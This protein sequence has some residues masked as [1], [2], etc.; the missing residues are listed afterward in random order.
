MQRLNSLCVISGLLLVVKLNL[1]W[2][3]CCLNHYKEKGN[4]FVEPWW[5]ISALKGQTFS[6]LDFSYLL[7]SCHLLRIRHLSKVCNQIPRFKDLSHLKTLYLYMTTC[8][9]CRERAFFFVS[10]FISAWSDSTWWLEELHSSQPFLEQVLWESWEQEGELITEG[11]PLGS[12][13][14]QSGEDARR[15]AEVEEEGSC[16]GAKEHG[17]TRWEQLSWRKVHNKAYY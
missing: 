7:Q 13:S 6:N 11:L 3:H 1:P 2:I 12:Q 17:Q 10:D 16:D 14:S 9:A 8:P 15:A 4:R 5:K